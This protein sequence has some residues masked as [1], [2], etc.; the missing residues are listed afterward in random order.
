MNKSVIVEKCR[1]TTE[2]HFY[3]KCVI[4]TKSEVSYCIL[5]R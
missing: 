3:L 5:A 4:K 1:A 2:E